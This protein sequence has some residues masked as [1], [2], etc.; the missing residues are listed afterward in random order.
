ME[1][2]VERLLQHV[3][4]RSGNEAPRVTTDGPAAAAATSGEAP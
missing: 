2:A 1:P 3:E 4:D